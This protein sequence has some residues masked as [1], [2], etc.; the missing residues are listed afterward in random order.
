MGALL[1]LEVMVDQVDH[2]NKLT[3]VFFNSMVHD[4]ASKGA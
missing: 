1:M 4:K 2:I 3:F